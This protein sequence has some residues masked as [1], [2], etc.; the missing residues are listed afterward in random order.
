M[1]IPPVVFYIRRRLPSAG[2]RTRDPRFRQQACKIFNY[3]IGFTKVLQVLNEANQERTRKQVEFNLPTNILKNKAFRSIILQMKNKS[4]PL[5]MLI[6]FISTRF[7]FAGNN[8][9]E[10]TISKYASEFKTIYNI[11]IIY[12]YEPSK[13]IAYSIPSTTK[14]ENDDLP[15]LALYLKE[16]QPE[17]SKYSE[18]FIKKINLRNIFLYK[19]SSTVDTE[20]YNEPDGSTSKNT[21]D[22]ISLN[23]NET[24]MLM[25]HH[26]LFHY[27]YNRA[28][29]SI[30]NWSNINRSPV[31]RHLL[32]VSQYA[33]KDIFEDMA[34]IYARLMIKTEA[35][36]LLNTVKS[37]YIIAT[38]IRLIKKFIQ[39]HF[40]SD[41]DS[42]YW[43][44]IIDG[45]DFSSELS[46]KN[47]PRVKEYVKQIKNKYY[48]SLNYEYSASSPIFSSNMEYKKIGKSDMA[49]FAAYLSNFQKELYKYPISLIKGINIK[50]INFYKDFSSDTTRNDNKIKI[51][52]IFRN[53]NNSI[54][55]NILVPDLKVFHHELFHWLDFKHPGNMPDWPESHLGQVLYLDRSIPGYASLYAAKNM[56][57]DK[58]E[59]FAFLMLRD[60][61]EEMTNRAKT[62]KLLDGKI[63][64]MKKFFQE[65]CSSEMNVDYWNKIMTG[66][67]FST[68]FVK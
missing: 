4:I 56:A 6:L 59:T 26:K 33:Q 14:I 35:L 17:L 47:E 55:L 23:I 60:K 31:P 44:N 10:V 7:Y 34:E 46:D 13:P 2:P 45:Y 30:Q 24:N 9:D 32:F 49:K 16:L 27:I 36:E 54:Y 61:A 11:S 29:A 21:N 52:G 67:D 5:I 58:A 19:S 65:K 66:F 39:E 50:D 37:E 1:R 12:R 25:F 15:R 20:R 38:K 40:S 64:L 43:Q 51:G 63:K 57:E 8:D 68:T 41:M 22:G 48:L 18:D 42:V 62:D 28:G 3:Y 53:D